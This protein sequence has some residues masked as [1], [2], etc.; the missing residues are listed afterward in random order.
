MLRLWSSEQKA[1]RP[2]AAE[3]RAMASSL[4]QLFEGI[5]LGEG[6]GQKPIPAWLRGEFPD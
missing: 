4:N 5:G 6:A 3:L 1:F 2:V